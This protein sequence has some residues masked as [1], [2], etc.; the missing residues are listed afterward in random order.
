[1]S[2]I[3]YALALTPETFWNELSAKQK[4]NVEVWLNGLNAKE[5]PDTNWL[6][7]VFSRVCKRRS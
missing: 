5:M 1:M 3:G 7:C 2:P 4:A 6:W